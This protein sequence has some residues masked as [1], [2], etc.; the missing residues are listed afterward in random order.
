[1]YV[2]KRDVLADPSFQQF[3]GLTTDELRQR[4][5]FYEKLRTMPPSTADPSDGG[6]FD[7]TLFLKTNMQLS[8]ETMRSSLD[9]DWKML[10]DEHKAMLIDSSL[11]PRPANEHMLQVIQR[12]DNPS[13]C[14]CAQVAPD[15]YQADPSCCPRG[16]ELAFTW[17][18]NGNL[19]VRISSKHCFLVGLS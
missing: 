18:K 7:R 5:D 16:I 9:S 8:T 2:S 13:R 15:E 17:R 3:A 10:S 12:A 11:R 19:E 14:S 4:P 1:L 6:F